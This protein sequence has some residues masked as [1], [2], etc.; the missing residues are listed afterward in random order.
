MKHFILILFS[1][2]GL[3][4]SLTGCKKEYSSGE[5]SKATVLPNIAAWFAD[6]Q[7]GRS[8]E[9]KTKIEAVRSSLD[10]DNS[11]TEQAGSIAMVIIPLKESLKLVNNQKNKVS[12]Y[13]L[14]N[15]NPQ[16]GKIASGFI[17]QSR[18]WDKTK[19]TAIKKGTFKNI[20]NGNRIENDCILTILTIND[21]FLY[22]SSYKNGSLNS[23]AVIH[24]GK[25][26][27]SLNIALP[28]A[29]T[30][31]TDWYFVTTTYYSD[32]TSE[33]DW[34]FI[35]QTC[36]EDCSIGD[37]MGQ[38]TVCDHLPEGEGG[39]GGGGTNAYADLF[40]QF[41]SYA[42]Q[43]IT[44][45]SVLAPATQVYGSDPITG[46][47]TWAVVKSA[48]GS[49]NVMADTKYSYYRERYYNILTSSYFYKFDLFEYQTLGSYYVGSNMFIES[50][51]TQTSVTDQ[52]F[53]NKTENTYGKSLVNGTIRHKYKLPLPFNIPTSV[54]LPDVT[55]ACSGPATFTPR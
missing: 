21:Q 51:W 5:A 29:G 30:E 36:T 19:S 55:T 18:D 34:Q 12:N 32:G 4:I 15:T 26:K 40:S 1:V 20:Q 39:A 11:W 8:P 53:N 52:V 23:A 49:W 35:G 25:K 9:L 22:E 14:L 6:Q 28:T 54:P 13:L 43:T 3:V 44:P 10:L 2:A 33:E 37:P 48:L 17:V 41:S 42:Q 38:T 45:A 46:V 16:T 31:C 7:K 50:T 27:D 47:F 24:K